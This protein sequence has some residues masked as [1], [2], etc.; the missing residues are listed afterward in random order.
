MTI[1]GE[2]LTTDF[3]HRLVGAMTA[4]NPRTADA[5][6]SDEALNPETVASPGCAS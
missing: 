1:F 6:K 3:Y 5:L 2:E 4:A